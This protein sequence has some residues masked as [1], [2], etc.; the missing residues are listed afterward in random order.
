[1]WSRS[2]SSPRA[3]KI[4]EITSLSKV[5]TTVRENLKSVYI[6]V[7]FSVVVIDKNMLLVNLDVESGLCNRYSCTKVRC[8]TL[9]SYKF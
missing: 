2:R 4:L 6:P 3:V 5:P 8:A 1:M 9:R 7:R